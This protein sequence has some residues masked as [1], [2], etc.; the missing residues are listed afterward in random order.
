MRRKP[1]FLLFVS[2]LLLL[3][4]GAYEVTAKAPGACGL[5]LPGWSASRRAER[6][7]VWRPRTGVGLVDHL[8]HESEEAARFYAYLLSGS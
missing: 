3:A 4:L 8:L 5:R 7:T 2:Y 6:A 1:V